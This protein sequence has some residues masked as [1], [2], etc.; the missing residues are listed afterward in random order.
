MPLKLTEDAPIELDVL[1]RRVTVA[2]DECQKQLLIHIHG[3]FGPVQ[4][5]PLEKRKG[6]QIRRTTLIHA[7]VSGTK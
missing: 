7:S 1:E 4:V 6:G 2:V 3:D 5:L